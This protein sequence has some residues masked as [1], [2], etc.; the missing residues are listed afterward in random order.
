M[1][2]VEGVGQVGGGDLSHDISEDAE[3][4]EEVDNDLMCSEVNSAVRGSGG[5]VGSE[6]PEEG[7]DE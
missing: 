5:G 3:H 2:V 6:G 4:H 1:W 7:L